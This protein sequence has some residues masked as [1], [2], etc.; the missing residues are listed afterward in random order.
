VIAL[1]QEDRARL[2]SQAGDLK[3]R[4]REFLAS[5]AQC[6]LRDG[7]TCGQADVVR[8]RAKRD[9]LGREIT[10]NGI[11]F[12]V[13]QFA[14]NVHCTRPHRSRRDTNPRGHIQVKLNP[15]LIAFDQRAI[16]LQ[17]AEW[18]FDC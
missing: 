11:P 7:V 8:A 4:P 16:R 1:R 17:L 5:N 14:L 13:E 12:T 6:I 18:H 3:R 10:S 9:R 2:L 15:V